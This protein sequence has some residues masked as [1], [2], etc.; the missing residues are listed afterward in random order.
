MA[1]ASGASVGITYVAE[2]TRGT[3][4]SSPTMITLRTTSRNLNPSKGLLTSNERRSNRQVQDARHGFKQVSGSL[5]FELGMSDYDAMILAAMS[6]SAWTAG[7]STGTTSLTSVNATSKFTRASGS[8]LT[9]G[10]KK[11]D[12]ITTTGMGQTTTYFLV[13]A[14]SAL[15]LTVSPAPVDNTA[16][17]DEVITVQGRTADIGSTLS[18]FTFERQ[19]ADITQFQTFTGCAIN[20]M[21]VSIQPESIVTANLDIVGMGFGNMSGTTLDATPTAAS[22]TSPFSAFDGSLYI[23][24]VAQTVVTG[25]DFQIQN[26]RGVQGVVGSNTSPDVFEGTAVVTGTLSYFLEDATLISLFE[27]ET[28][29]A[30]SIKL[31]ELGD[32]SDFHSLFFPRIKLNTSDIDPGQE[33]PIVANATFQA[34]YD[35][36]NDTSLRWQIANA[37]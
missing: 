23:D 27:D 2:T 6:D 4:P 11:G 9:D 24:G 22:F 12:Y 14:A 1:L 34:L 33:G 19:F 13:T 36:T 32:T 28:E 7:V 18:T 15:E 20:T 10:I 29:A 37:S 31:D 3:T 30:L 16:D 26:G 8:F 25:V 35:S 21:S 5:G 17:A